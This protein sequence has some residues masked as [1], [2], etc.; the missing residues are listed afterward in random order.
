[1]FYQ[2]PPALAPMP[3]NRIESI[4][5]MRKMTIVATMAQ[6]ISLSQSMQ[7]GLIT[8]PHWSFFNTQSGLIIQ[9]PI[10]MIMATMIPEITA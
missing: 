1:M 3:A 6:M 4:Q 9:K 2:K 8:F 10:P 5:I 7:H